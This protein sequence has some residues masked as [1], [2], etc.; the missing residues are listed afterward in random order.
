MGRLCKKG[1]RMTQEK[2]WL[3]KLDTWRRCDKGTKA[4][5][6]MPING[7]SDPHKIACFYAY[8]TKVYIRG[9]SPGWAPFFG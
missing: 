8:Y 5:R 6:I 9:Y 2:S 1:K 7:L 4:G 3:A